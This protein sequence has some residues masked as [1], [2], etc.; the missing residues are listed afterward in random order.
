[1][2]VV[3]DYWVDRGN[4]NLNYIIMGGG[5]AAVPLQVLDIATTER[6]NVQRGVPFVLTVRG[7]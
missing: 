5:P 1:M 4:L 2:Y 6:I 7:D 3:G